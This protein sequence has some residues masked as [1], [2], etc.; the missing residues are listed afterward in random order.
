M[1]NVIE[2]D[3]KPNR[4]PLSLTPYRA[5]LLCIVLLAL[6]V[7]WID[8]PWPEELRLKHIPTAIGIGLLLWGH[9]RLG[10]SDTSFTLIIVFILLHIIGAQWIYK[11]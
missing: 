9:H 1:T 7:R 5:L 3:L 6:G 10:I 11:I 8:A 4:L 2:G